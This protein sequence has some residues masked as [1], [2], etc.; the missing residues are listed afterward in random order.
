MY[1]F[2][3]YWYG[4]SLTISLPLAKRHV[5]VGW[6]YLRMVHW[7]ILLPVIAVLSAIFRFFFPPANAARV[8][9]NSM[10][11]LQGVLWFA[12]SLAVWC[13]VR[14]LLRRKEFVRLG[15]GRVPRGCCRLIFADPEVFERF[16]VQVKIGVV[17][18]SEAVP[19]PRSHA[20]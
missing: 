11:P 12:G 7:A 1:F 3:A 10:T 6:Q 14:S 17:K 18:T 15:D 20:V 9:G 8:H 2:L 4:R 5:L 19:G 13:L 16:V